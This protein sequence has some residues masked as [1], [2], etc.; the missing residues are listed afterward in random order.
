MSRNPLADQVW[1][2]MS[3]LVLDN[4]DSWRRAV[5]ERTGLPWSR[6]RILRRLARAPMTVKQVAEAATVDAPAATVAVNHLE[7]R[8]LVLRR[9]SPDNRRCKLV[10]L[11]EAGRALVAAIE[12]VDDPAPDA[13][14]GLAD[15][16]LV[17]LRDVLLRLTELTGLQQGHRRIVAADA[18]HSATPTRA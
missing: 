4:R 6:I 9:T 13:L 12:E 2:Q 14:A 1:R 15:A 17:A 7:A 18:R 10:S 8:G 3:A 5:V 16:D 11:T